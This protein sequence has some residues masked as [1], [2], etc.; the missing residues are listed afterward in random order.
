MKK[1]VLIVQRFYYN[2]REGFFN[3][4]SDIQYD[5]K[6]INSTISRGK[7]KVHDEAKKKHFIIKT[8]GIFL[9]DKHIFFPFLFFNLIWLNPRLIVAEGGANTI[10]IIP[11]LLYCKLFRRKYIIWD[12]GKGFADFG[13]STLRRLYMIFYVFVLKH[14]D[15]IY[16]YNSQ[17]KLYFKS[18]GVSE[19]K[20]VILNNTIDTRKIQMIRSGYQFS[21]P[22]EF[23]DKKTKDFI[24]L[25][26]VGALVKSKNIEDLAELMKMLGDKYFLII[27]GEATPEYKSE[28]DKSF[29]GTNHVFLGYR[30]LEQLLP[31]YVMSSFSV[32]PGLGGLSI[33]QSM[34]YGVPVICKSADGTEKDLIIPGKTGYIYEDLED[35][36]SFIV[37]RSA[38]DWRRMGVEAEKFLYSNHSVEIMM[39]KFI[40]YL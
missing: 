11:I 3:Y 15:F 34:A 38:E 19:N 8:P 29:S 35:A 23:Y 28:L 17:S 9:D 6:L 21:L 2:F 5:F 13:N 26:F 32:L 40:S 10:N 27:A 37:S 30:K 18:L 20:V 1:G 14:A 12:L 24:F 39:T 7:V 22:S 16:G 33:N 31:Y 25:I 4:L 36:C